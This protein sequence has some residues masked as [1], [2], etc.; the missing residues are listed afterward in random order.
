M[1]LKRITARAIAEI[2]SL[3]PPRPQSGLRIFLYHSVGVGITEQFYGTSLPTAAFRRQMQ[4]LSQRSDLTV[5]NLSD[6]QPTD[7]RFR[8][9]ISFDDGYR[10]NLHIAAPILTEM[11]ITAMF[12]VTASFVGNGPDY[13]SPPELQELASLPGM[14]IGSHG[15]TH[16]RLTACDDRGLRRELTD[17]RQFLEDLIGKPV[18]A[19]S[20]PHGAINHRVRNAAIQAGYIVGATSRY[21]IN[22]PRQDRLCLHRC[23]IVS[24]DTERV[25]V[26]KLSGGWDWRGRW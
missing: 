16:C 2:N 10:D 1:R 17:S 21:G 22:G 4:L 13:L 6:S 25:F 7:S 11:K 14:A 18:T 12:F 20:Y 5:T 9:A 23:E 19:I 24:Q 15:L 8:V 3:P 26:Q